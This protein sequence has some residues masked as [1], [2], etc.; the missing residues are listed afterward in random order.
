MSL[1]LLSDINAVSDAEKNAEKHSRR[2]NNARSAVVLGSKTN[3]SSMG[4]KFRISLIF[5]HKTD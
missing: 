2:Q 3:S 1:I 4:R 5:E